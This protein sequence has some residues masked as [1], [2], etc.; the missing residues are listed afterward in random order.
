VVV[1]VIVVARMAAGGPVA[2]EL[3]GRYQDPLHD[4]KRRGLAWPDTGRPPRLSP[5]QG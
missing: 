4:E 1:V 2:E 5:S 3:F